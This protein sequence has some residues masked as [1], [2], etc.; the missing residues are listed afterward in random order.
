MKGKN[1]REGSRRSVREAKRRARKPTFEASPTIVKPDIHLKTCSMVLRQILEPPMDSSVTGY[2]KR[3]H[4]TAYDI[5]RQG[6]SFERSS[7]VCDVK[8][9]NVSSTCI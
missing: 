4:T 3:M 5:L 8:K 7:S 6:K 2:A 1:K 9:L